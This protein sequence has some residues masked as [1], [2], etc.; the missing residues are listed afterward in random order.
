VPEPFLFQN[1]VAAGTG[2]TAGSVPVEQGTQT[3]TDQVT[4]VYAV[5]E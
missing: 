1:G 2:A 4:V 3:E 5:S